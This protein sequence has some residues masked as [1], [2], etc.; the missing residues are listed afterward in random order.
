MQQQAFTL[1]ELIITV[2]LIALLTALSLPQLQHFYQQQRSQ[3]TAWA[4]YNLLQY[5]RHK[6][7][8]LG[9]TLT[10]C[11]D[12]GNLQCRSGNL[13]QNPRLLLFIDNNQN[14]NRE[15]DEEIL[16]Q[17]DLSKNN[18]SIHWRSFGNK[19]YLQWQNNGMTFY[20]N[21]SFLYCPANKNERYGFLIVINV[22]GRLYQAQDQNGDGIVEDSNNNN[23]VCQ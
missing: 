16:Y 1:I 6:A 18:G 19:A 22:L 3:Q 11:A 21:G 20:Q 14:G 5:S 10:L 4:F 2:S 8:Q 12:N 23:I 17:L 7:I 15:A 13:W 9:K